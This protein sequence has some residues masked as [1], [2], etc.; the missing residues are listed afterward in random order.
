MRYPRAL[1]G[2]RRRRHHP[3][4]LNRQQVKGIALHWPAMAQPLA[5]VKA[6]KAALRGWQN[7]HMDDQG[8]SDLAYQVAVDQRGHHYTIRGLRRKSAAN[9]TAALNNEYGA[10]LLVLAPGEQPSAKMIRK[11]TKL[12]RRHRRRFPNSSE[13]VGHG[14]IRPGG[15]TCPGPATQ[16]LI[17]RGRFEP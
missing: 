17:D 13:I 6:V 15:T 14:E 8:W 5:T 4:T 3:G 9:G 7:F 1:W 10:V 16:R 12:V 2:A 11:V